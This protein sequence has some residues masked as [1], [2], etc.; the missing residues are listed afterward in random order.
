MLPVSAAELASIQTDAVLA[1]CDQSCVIKRAARTPDAQGGAS[2]TWNTI[3]TVNAGMAEPSANQLANYQYMIGSLAAWQVRV[4]VGTNV[5]EQDQLVIG[6]QTLNV[7]KI[8]TPRS[9]PG[10]LTALA[11]EVK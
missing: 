10:L 1:A 7:V 2:V 8:L 5:L 9:Y 4:P 6:G 11:A 3:A